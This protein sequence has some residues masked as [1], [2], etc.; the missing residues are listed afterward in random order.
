MKKFLV[1]ALLAVLLASVAAIVTMPSGGSAAASQ[2]G[3]KNSPTGPYLDLFN[4]P[5]DAFTGRATYPAGT[6]FH[7]NGGWLLNKGK[8]VTKDRTVEFQVDAGGLLPADFDYTDTL[9]KHWVHN[10]LNGLSGTHTLTIHYAPCAWT[11][12]GPIIEH[13]LQG[14]TLAAEVDFP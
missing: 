1:A 3:P 10:F 7:L 13:N 2:Y 6:S 8:N 14:C 5:R 12:P 4:P 11:G 9:G